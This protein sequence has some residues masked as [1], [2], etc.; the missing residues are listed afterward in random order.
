MYIE[1]W[2]WICLFWRI[3]SNWRNQYS[4]G[5]NILPVFLSV[6]YVLISNLLKVNF[7]FHHS[8][9]DK[10]NRVP[11][12]KGGWNGR[13]IGA[14]DRR[15]CSISSAHCILN[16]NCNVA[17]LG[18]KLISLPSLTPSLDLWFFYKH[19]VQVSSLMITHLFSPRFSGPKKGS[20]VAT[21][22]LD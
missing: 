16:S 5:R 14:L 17:F 4:I 15:L 6:S 19:S 20:W 9:I 1:K 13:I 11:V 3:G 22:P 7:V 12:K 10:K 2:F 8:S 18:G 21:F